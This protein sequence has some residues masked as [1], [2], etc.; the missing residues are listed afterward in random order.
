MMRD[1][2][3]FKEQKIAPTGGLAQ[4]QVLHEQSRALQHEDIQRA[5]Q[6]VEQAINLANQHYEDDLNYLP[7]LA[8][9][10]HLHG[11]LC[12]K[13]ADYGTALASYNRALETYSILDNQSQM[14][15]MQNHIGDH[16]TSVQHLLEAYRIFEDLGEYSRQ[17]IILNNLGFTHVLV[18]QHEKALYYLLKGLKLARENDNKFAQAITLDSLCHAYRG[19]KEYTDALAYGL[20]SIQVAQELG[21]QRDECEYCLSVGMVYKIRGDIVNTLSYYERSL[22]LAQ[23]LGFRREEAEALRE[24]A[25]IYFQQG[26]NQLAFS[27]LRRALEIAESIDARHESFKTHFDLAQA[28]KETG[29]FK[30]AFAHYERF[31]TIKEQVFNDQ[32][33]MRFKSLE[34]AHR[35]EQ[36]Q[37]EAKIY[38]LEN[39]A[40]QTEIEERKQAQAAAEHIATFDAL[41][42][43]YNRR[44]F[45]HLAE[46]AFTQALYDNTP[47]CIIMFDIDHFKEVN[48]TYG[49]LIGDQV[50]ATVAHTIRTS[51]RT[52]NRLHAK[53]ILGRYGGEEFAIILAD[54]NEEQGTIVAERIRETI[55]TT[56]VFTKKGSISVTL[57][58]GIGKIFIDDS[59]STLTLNVLIDRADQALYMAKQAGRNRTIVFLS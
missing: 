15:L 50:L 54:A 40:L 8:E 2:L 32:A 1:P 57:S 49:H 46:H 26:Q 25:S 39:Q 33:D 10:L 20:E 5:L 18:D 56:Q 42:G 59:F 12:D 53:D 22:K 45:F 55:E 48:D 3:P 9:S 6:L 17:S 47:L 27:H 28:F 43:L 13:L 21:I 23:K 52:T 36:A 30:K 58:G 16:S 24:L 11:L 37:K 31:H 35:L 7:S 44:H 14:A 38:R 4:I 34:T 29:D 41:T 19:L 51:L